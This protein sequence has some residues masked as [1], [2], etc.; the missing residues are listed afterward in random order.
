MAAFT[1]LSWVWA[2]KKENKNIL[3]IFE[4]IGPK[5]LLIHRKHLPTSVNTGGRETQGRCLGCRSGFSTLYSTTLEAQSQTV[6]FKSDCYLMHSVPPPM[7]AHFTCWYWR[8]ADT[9]QPRHQKRVP[10]ATVKWDWKG[11][12][13]CTYFWHRRQPFRPFLNFGRTFRMPSHQ[14]TV[15]QTGFCANFPLIM[16]H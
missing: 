5:R 4:Y 1:T 6:Q 11:L 3:L 7:D 9:F 14:L 13:F 8:A 2:T 15:P 10:G 12:G 16:K